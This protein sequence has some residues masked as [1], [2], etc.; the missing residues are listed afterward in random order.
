MGLE[1]ELTK[2]I[3]QSR[4]ISQE[5]L[6]TIINAPKESAV[7]AVLSCLDY[8][9]LNAL[10][11]AHAI[12]DVR[13][14][15]K[16]I[17]YAPEG[18][19][20]TCAIYWMLILGKVRSKKAFDRIRQYTGTSLF[21]QAFISLAKIDLAKATALF[22]NFLDVHCQ[23][24]DRNNKAF[25]HNSGFNTLTRLL[26]NHPAARALVQK[27]DISKNERKKRLVQDALA[28]E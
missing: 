3:G 4:H 28:Y 22:E 14:E 8:P 7:Q 26:E 6:N 20:E 24:Y 9:N 27:Y 21:H 12:P 10:V 16:L 13:Y 11:A 18:M 17:T 25:M 1:E 19:Q 23:F 5:E 2:I 15:E